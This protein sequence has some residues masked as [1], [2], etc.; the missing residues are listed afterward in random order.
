MPPLLSRLPA[1]DPN[2]G[3]L[4]AVIET[5]KGSLNKYDY[6]DTCAAFR[7]AQVMPKGSYSP[8][9]LASSHPLSVTMVIRWMCWSSWM[10]LRRS[11]VC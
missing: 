10:I 5:P 3:D 9:T 6:D 8:M 4:L 11:V 7:L 1:T 2:T